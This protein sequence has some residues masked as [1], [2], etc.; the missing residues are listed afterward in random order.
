M[1]AK[2][3]E[4]RLEVDKF[5]NY[6][7]ALNPSR[8]VSL[9]HTNLQRAKAWLGM[10]LGELGTQTP[11]PVSSDPTSAVIEPQAE[12]FNQNIWVDPIKFPEEQPSL[13]QTQTSHVKFFRKQIELYQSKFENISLEIYTNCS[14]LSGDMISYIQ[15]SKFSMIEAKHWL[16]W[17][18]DR[19]RKQ[20]EFYEAVKNGT[21]GVCPGR[22]L[23]PL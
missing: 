17:E 5:I 14:E 7:H 3:R 16:G 20:K 12:H 23:L 18:L 15:Q 4:L 21:D 22:A 13:E 2:I 10:V 19:I 9:C 1:E 11:Y 6:T 8:E